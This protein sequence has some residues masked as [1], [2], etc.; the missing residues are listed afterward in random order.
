MAYYGRASAFASAKKP[1]NKGL[2]LEVLRALKCWYS[3]RDFVG[4]NIESEKK[5]SFF[6]T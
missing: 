5:T 4:T 2:A 6:F 3:N 1:L